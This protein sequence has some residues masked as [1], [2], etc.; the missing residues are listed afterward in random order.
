M[1]P[2]R[3]CLIALLS[4]SIVLVAHAQLAIQFDYRYDTNGFFTESRRVLLSSAASVFEHRMTTETFQAITP[5]GNNHFS[6]QF[7]DPTTNDSVTLDQ[8]ALL[9][10]TLTIFVG[11]QN[12]GTSTLGEGASVGYG[13]SGDINFAD[14]FNRRDNSTNY[15]PFGGVISFSSDTSLW[16]FD[17]DPTTLESFA[18][19]YDF[20]SVALHEIGHVLGFSEGVAAFDAHVT[21]T[22]FSGTAV[23]ALYGGPAPLAGSSDLS[24]WSQG[25]TYNGAQVAMAP[26]IAANQRKTFTELDFAVLSDIGYQIN[27]IPEPAFFG[28]IALGGAGLCLR[29]R[30]KRALA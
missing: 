22:T 24:H 4:L 27:P 16:Y 30:R 14:L 5:G 29:R 17:S 28:L 20:Y 15:D 7:Y 6:L 1:R 10:N 2:I 26:A 25:L 12:L 11:A 23:N 8:F 13:Y 18:G 3:P 19:K 9:A 21:G